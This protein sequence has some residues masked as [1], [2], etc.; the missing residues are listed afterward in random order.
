MN[1]DTPLHLPI[2]ESLHSDGT[3]WELDQF[4]TSDELVSQTHA[5]MK[6][7]EPYVRSGTRPPA[8][9]FLD[10]GARK[11][12]EMVEVLFGAYYPDVPTPEVEYIN[13][14][15]PRINAE[16]ETVIPFRGDPHIIQSNYS[17]QAHDR[18]LIIDD[19]AETND[20]VFK[21]RKAFKNAYPHA[22]VMTMVAYT[23]IPQW[24]GV[25]DY[26]GVE[27]YTT[28]DFAH[29][30]LQRLNEE[31]ASQGVH[32][33]DLHEMYRYLTNDEISRRFLQLN[34]E[35][36]G[37]I[38]RTRPLRRSRFAQETV[39]A[40]IQTICQAVLALKATEGK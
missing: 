18:I 5:F 30:A 11:I 3:K 38:P 39:Q 19:Y 8:M 6:R 4:L 20:T 24:Q 14:G 23:K 32:F 7:L 13:I 10:K 9:V 37:S 12:G 21:A 22:E 40:E 35:L 15:R 33:G 1:R 2:Y 36:T 17:L 25:A 16:K 28:Q 31:I 27:E 34:N 29:I 26:A